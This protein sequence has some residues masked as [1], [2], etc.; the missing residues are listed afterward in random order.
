MSPYQRRTPGSLKYAQQRLVSAVGGLEA[1]EMVLEGRVKRGQI[2]RYT[3]E[4]DDNLFV[5]MPADV[6]RTLERVAGC[7]IVT[8][9]LAAEAGAML[10]PVTMCESRAETY[11][12]HLCAVGEKSGDLF[13]TMTTALAD[14]VMTPSEAGENMAV[15]MRLTSAL[16]V[17]Y[18][19]L[20]RVR[21]GEG[22]E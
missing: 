20:G 14:G 3:S 7:P 13:R 11:L 22:A 17:L 21:D 6:I 16:A 12:A 2:A 18:A 10:V 5:H 9:F 8:E 4:I 19:R 15:V 1:A